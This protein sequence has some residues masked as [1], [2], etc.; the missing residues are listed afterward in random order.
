[1]TIKHSLPTRF[2][3]EYVITLKPRMSLKTLDLGIYNFELQNMEN[4]FN[5]SY[6]LTRCYVI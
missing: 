4:F 6:C 1:M 3:R 2:L 5:I